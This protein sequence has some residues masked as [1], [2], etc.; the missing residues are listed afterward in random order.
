MSRHDHPSRRLIL[1][2]TAGAGLGALAAPALAQAPWP[3]G[4]TIRLVVPFP[5]AG[6]TDNLA[7][8]VASRLQEMWGAS[9]VVENRGGAGGN[10]GTEAVKNAA[11]DGNTMLIV[12]VGMATNQFLYPRLGYDPV[13][14]F[15]P[16]TLIA[17]VPNILIVGRHVQANS[18]AELIERAR[19]NPGMTY[20]T[21]GIG[22]SVHLSGEL[23]QRMA[24]VR[25]EAVHYRGTAQATQDLIGGRLDM[26]FDNI[27]QSLPLVRAGQV[28]ALGITTARRSASAPDLVPVAET[29]PGFDVT[30][31]FAFFHPARTPPEMTERL[32]ADTATILREAGVR[33]RM[34]ALG[35]EPVG[36]SPAELAAHL[37]AESAR[38][39]RLIREAGI[40]A[41]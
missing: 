21:S 41:E 9:I 38:W 19:A 18:V 3:Q 16:A 31:W 2:A 6:A 25:L 36:S 39:G 32:R 1:G 37:A 13:A 34:A 27:A 30:S 26:I 15:A 7:R 4:R 33:E 8:I 23:F 22:T 24:N 20:G 17:L 14:D 28:K 12:S 40:R 10:I 5:P 35:A 11:P 29:V